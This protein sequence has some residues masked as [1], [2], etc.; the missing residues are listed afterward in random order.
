MLHRCN[1]ARYSPNASSNV[2]YFFV[3]DVKCN[4]YEVKKTNRANAIHGL[5]PVQKCYKTKLKRWTA[6]IQDLV[7]Y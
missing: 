3:A 7:L 6:E 1:D 4:L 5:N 2:S